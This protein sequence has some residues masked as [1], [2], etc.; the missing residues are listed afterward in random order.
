LG[1]GTPEFISAKP[2]DLDTVVLAALAHEVGHVRWYEKFVATP[3]S[4]VHDLK[5]F[6]SGNFFVGWQGG[7][8]KVTKPG[9]WRGLENLSARKQDGYQKHQNSPQTSDIDTAIVQGSFSNA[10]SFL[11]Q[12]YA[13]NEWPSFFGSITADEDF[14]EAYKL[15]VLTRATTP[16]T[17]LKLSIP[18]NPAYGGDIPA[19]ISNDLQAKLQCF[20][21]DP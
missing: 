9:P 1:W 8:G 4:G 20:D 12:I 14:V 18:T 15:W 7:W 5:K 19:N 10:G 2:D 21:Q 3:G 13:G 6:C 17:S 16:L 11:A